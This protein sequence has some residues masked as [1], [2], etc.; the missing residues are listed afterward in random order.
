MGRPRRQSGHLSGTF[1]PPNIKPNQGLDGDGLP[2]RQPLQNRLQQPRLSLPIREVN[3]QSSALQYGV[4]PVPEEPFTP[5]SIDAL[6]PVSTRA[7]PSPG[8]RS[9]STCYTGALECTR[10]LSPDANTP[11]RSTSSGSSY[12][13]LCHGDHVV[14]AP[15]HSPLCASDYVPLS[16]HPMRGQSPCSRTSSEA[17]TL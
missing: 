10:H 2:L 7:A 17:L 12:L 1:K 11:S 3:C 15:V 16:E 6:S 9:A 14:E 13:N 8:N 5:S 4:F